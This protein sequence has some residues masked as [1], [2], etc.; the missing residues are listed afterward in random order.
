M[1]DESYSPQHVIASLHAN[2]N[3]IF[4]AQLHMRGSDAEMDDEYISKYL[5]ACGSLLDIAKEDASINGQQV[6]ALATLNGLCSWV[7]ECLDNDGKVSDVL[8]GLTHGTQPNTL[9]QQKAEKSG[10]TPPGKRSNQKIQTNAAT[11]I[12]KKES[13]RIKMLEAVRAIATGEPR[14]G[15]SVVG[16]GTYRDGRKGWVALAREYTQLATNPD[17]V[18]LDASY[19]GRRGLEEVALYK[20]RDGEVTKIEHL[21]HTQPEYLR[22]AGGAM[23]RLFFV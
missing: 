9:M 12:L 5:A 22:E 2:Q 4:G 18:T 6:Q 23:A 13:Q 21:A 17:S 8:I 11:L 19:V 15:H 20:S 1:H 7:T 3:V 16:A 14:P 10:N